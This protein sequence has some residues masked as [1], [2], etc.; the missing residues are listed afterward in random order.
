MVLV[1]V[2]IIAAVVYAALMLAYRKGWLAKESIAMP[3]SYVPS[4]SISVIIPARDEE[5]NIASCINSILAQNYPK[6]LLEIVVIDDHSTDSTASIVNGYSQSNVKCLSLS[7]HLRKE[8]LIAYKKAALTVGVNNT[9][10]ALIVTTD[11]DCTA[12]INWLRSIAYEYEQWKPVMIIAPVDYKADSSVLQVFQSLDFMSMQGI[13]VAAH[14]LHMGNMCNGANLAFSRQAFN[15]VG[16]Y[17]NIDHLASGD[18]YLLLMKMSEK[19]PPKIACLKGVDAIVKTAPQYT[20]KGF[21]QQRVRWASKSGKY[22]DKRMTLILAFVYVFNLLFLA[23]LV[24]GLFNSV[25]LWLFLGLL[26]FKIEIELIYLYPVAQF[27]KK[28]K[29]LWLFPFLQPLH[30]LYIIVAGL[31]GLVGVY[32]WKGRTVK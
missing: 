23:V 6:E 12:G 15:A 14:E 19:F 26:L 24:V 28:K 9:K 10:G 2:S 31:L 25:Y 11:A 30:I 27:F 22:D 13:T 7:E 32:Q 18:D 29:Q 1:A 21:L 16:G 20:W 5:A 3:A 4:V 8:E 17:K